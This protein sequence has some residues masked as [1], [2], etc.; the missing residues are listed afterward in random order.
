MCGLGDFQRGE[1]FMEEETFKPGSG[2]M[3]RSLFRAEEGTPGKE[4]K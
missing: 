1:V 4:N 3:R 2:S